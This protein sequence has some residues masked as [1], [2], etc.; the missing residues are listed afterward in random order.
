MLNRRDLL[1]KCLAMGAVT[2]TSLLSPSN[3]A[4]AW[5]QRER[6][7]TP[8]VELGPFYKKLAPQTRNLR[9]PGDPGMPLTVA[10]EVFTVRGETIE[11][12]TIEVWHTDHLGH[13][14]LEG[15]HYRAKLLTPRDGK[16][17]FDSVIPGHYPG[18]VC[19]HIHYVV[20]APGHKPL[21]T[22]LYFA[23]DP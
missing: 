5:Q 3:L 7:P 12:A 18:R 19:Q 14:D 23:T 10:G 13:Y 15:Y 4:L 20:T 8:P 9:S 2:T 22:Q 21:I 17:E 16:Y 6:T 1:A 11:G